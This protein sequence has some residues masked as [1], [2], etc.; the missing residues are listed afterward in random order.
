[1]PTSRRELMTGAVTT[2]VAL[3]AAAAA[4]AQSPGGAAG[5]KP[6]KAQ[7]G[8]LII[9][10]D[11]GIARLTLSNPGLQNMITLK[12]AADIEAFC[13]QVDKDQT[14]GAVLIDGADG[15]FSS[16]AD[17]S[18]LAGLSANPTSSESLANNSTL[19]RFFTRIG[20]LPVPS[21]S[22]VE[23]GAVGAATNL[24]LA[25]DLTLVTPDA[26]ID[27]AFTANGIHP[28]GGHLMLLGRRAGYPAA[29]AFGMLGQTLTGSE[30][31]ARRLAYAAYPAAELLP[32][33]TR[34]VAIAA[35]D[36]E[37]A[38][39]VKKSLALE[40]GA[41]MVSWPAAVEIERGVQMWSM[42]RKG[43]AGWR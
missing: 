27:T 10:R 4:S 17:R 12:M 8:R 21:V 39:K 11:G 19:Y 36:P 13:D 22:L 26:V 24:M 30:A 16:G 35:K 43:R 9:T 34:L 32:A 42:A 37:L 28:G 20:E 31:V 3:G 33:A 15:Y 2:A 18:V 6:P 38:R 23:G 29:A 14:I 25:T 41:G 5:N 40:I 1:M 7:D